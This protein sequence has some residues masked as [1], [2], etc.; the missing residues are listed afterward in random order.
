MANHLRHWE[1]GAKKR[2]GEESLNPPE[3]ASLILDGARARLSRIMGVTGKALFHAFKC[4]NAPL[5]GSRHLCALSPYAL[6]KPE[7]A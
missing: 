2:A 6:P 1:R 7:G 5:A 3:D 4:S